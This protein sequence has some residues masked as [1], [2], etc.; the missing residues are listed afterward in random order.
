MY[1][2]G[3]LYFMPRPKTDGWYPIYISISSGIFGLIMFLK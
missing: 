2:F 1:F 3:F